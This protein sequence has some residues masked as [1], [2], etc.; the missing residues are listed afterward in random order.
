MLFTDKKIFNQFS[1]YRGLKSEPTIGF[2]WEAKSKTAKKKTI[3]LKIY[4]LLF[5]EINISNFQ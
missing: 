3:S 1:A 2:L 5:F 4:I